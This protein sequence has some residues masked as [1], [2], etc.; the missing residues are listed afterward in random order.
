MLARSHMPL[1]VSAWC[2]TAV[3]LGLSVVPLLV[4]LPFAA[5]GGLLPDIDHPGSTLGRKLPLISH[6]IR[7]FLGH[8]G[9]THSLLALA[10]SL[11]GLYYLDVHGVL[12]AVSL[13]SATGAGCASL[14]I[15]S[16]S[17]LMADAMTKS[18]VPLLWPWNRVFRS[19]VALTTGSWVETVVTV[20]LVGAAML[21]V[22][23]H[24]DLLH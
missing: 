17:H 1:A 2:V 8:R 18:G 20:I 6:L 19:P 5:V 15:G 21:Y 16:V 13:T 3:A 11:W 23:H 24:Y 10:G 22:G 7:M 4:G 12:H 9:F 14:L